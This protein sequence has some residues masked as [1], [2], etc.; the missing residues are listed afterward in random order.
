MR[1]EWCVVRLCGLALVF[2]IVGCS[3]NISGS[4]LAS[5]KNAVVWLQ[6]VRTPDNHLTGQMAATVLQPNGSIER[7]SAPITGAVDGENVTISG[8]RFFGL[9]SFTFSG[10]L[11]GDTL[12]L[13][14]AQSS[15]LI[16]AR[17]TL[18]KFQTA[19]TELTDHSQSVIK[20]NAAIQARQRTYQAERNFTASVYQ[21]ISRME[22]FDSEEDVH[23]GRFPGAEK[24]YEEITAKVAGYVARERQLAGN[25]NASVTRG[26][27][28]VAANQASIQTEQMHNQTESLELALQT[29]VKPT[30]DESANLEQRCLSPKLNTGSLNPA[31]I[32]N[33][34]AACERLESVVTPFRQKF[35]AMSAGL[36]RLEQVYQREQKAQQGLIQE[37]EKLQ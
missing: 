1:R 19:E 35:D 25:P 34:Y 7:N 21:L 6:I 8:S 3:H 36:A 14:G 32:Q 12:T 2:V 9:E 31:E 28:S 15:P 24:S 16:L 5:D 17:S 26:Q 4:Y 37:S 23:L 20:T 30:A 13:S 10:T 27:L 18:A 29:N 22:R 11:K 33:V